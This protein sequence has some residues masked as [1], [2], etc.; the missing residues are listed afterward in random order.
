MK[1]H[2]KNITAGIATIATI[3]ISGCSKDFFNRPPEAGITVG[4]YYQTVSQV[5]A[6]TNGLY[7]SPWF[8]WNNKVGWAI[9]ELAGGNAFTYSSDVSAFNDWSAPNGNPEILAA[10]DSPFTVIA[11]C[12]GLINNMASSIPGVPQATVNNALG[13]AH[14]MRAVAYFYLVRVFGNVPIVENPLDDI[15]NFQHVP[16]NYISDVYTFMI[17]DLQFAEANCSAGTAG[18][19]HGDSGSAS[20]M[21]AKVYLYMQDY[22]N[23]QK[24][25]EKVIN[26]GEFSLLPVYENLFQTAFNNNKESILAMQ[27]IYNGGYDYGNSIQASWAYNSTITGTGDGYAEIGPTIDLQNAFKTEGGDTIRRHATIM[28]P[29]SKYPDLLA[30]SGG[31][32]F[33]ANGSAQNENAA[34]KKYV[35][36]TPADNGGKSAAQAG[37][38]NTYIMRYSDVLLIEAE[39]ILGQAAHV[40]PGT[41]IPLTA[42]TSDPKALTYFNMVRTRVGVPAVTSFTYQQL[43]L[44]RRLEFALEQ[45]FWFDLCRLDGFQPSGSAT[46][47]THH[48]VGIS[49]ISQQE[50]GTYSAAA[51]ANPAPVIYSRKLTPIDANFFFPVPVSEST[52]DPNLVAAPVHYVFK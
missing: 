46:F 29:G 32:T 2:I 15:A 26:S 34:A 50:R 23:A 39:A 37:G 3:V 17:K 7:G 45:D 5:Q 19:G 27:W 43:L 30:A 44:E 28:L 31:Y 11:Q 16:T 36:G 47:P 14:L 18:T 1:R 24:E 13:E 41:G 52:T 22:V 25:A 20:A 40:T 8:G 49:V 9:T 35:I 38:N 12:N 4:N 10:W 21:L 42:S 33:P 48:P 51:N 6:S